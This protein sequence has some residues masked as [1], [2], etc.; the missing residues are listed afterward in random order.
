MNQA[1][2]QNIANKLTEKGVSKACPRCPSFNFEVVGQ[3]QVSLT[4]NLNVFSLG[5]TIIPAVI[6][7]C[8]KCGFLTFHAISTFSNQIDERK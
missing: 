8:S 5:G 7:A 6:V 1:D 3:T 4:E 2:K